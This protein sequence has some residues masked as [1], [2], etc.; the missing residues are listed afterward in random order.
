MTRWARCALWLKKYAPEV[1]NWVSREH[2]LAVVGRGR[3]RKSPGCDGHLHGMTG[4][5]GRSII[6]RVGSN[7]DPRVS[8]V[9]LDGEGEAL[10][11]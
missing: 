4:L 8:E 10:A 3:R 2:A 7:H 11:A 9:C 5:S 6:V 1:E